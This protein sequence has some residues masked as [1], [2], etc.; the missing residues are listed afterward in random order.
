MKMLSTLHCPL[1]AV[2]L[3]ALLSLP[4]ARGDD[5]TT[6]VIKFSDPAKPGVVK[7]DVGHGDIRIRG[8]EK[9][10]AVTLKT[11]AKMTT[12]APRS[13]GL[14]NLTPPV[15][16]SL[17]E[18]NNVVTIE[19]TSDG[20]Q[21]SGDFEINVPQKTS[22]VIRNSWGGSITCSNL[23]GDV[24][25]KSMNG[26]VK[27]DGIAGGVLVETMNGEIS[28]DMREVL[29]GK[30]LS[31]T[32]MNG[33]IVIRVPEQTKAT[34]SLRSQ[35]AAILTDFDE[36]ALVTETK[37]LP[38]G[39]K[40]AHVN[41]PGST[42]IQVAVRDAIAVGLDV[43]REATEAARQAADAMR[44]ATNSMKDNGDMSPMPKMKSVPPMTGGKI[45][46][47]ALNGGG[48]DIQAATMNG[49]VILRKLEPKK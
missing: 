4:I 10:T 5:T 46:S 44:D 12:P 19:G 25:I 36:K 24:E 9:E 1:F 41:P 43:A 33:K 21:Q 42:D 14:R 23:N 35:N 39:K 2:A 18:Q 6:N 28:A 30:P 7:V 27:L 13:D 17:S 40:V 22:V 20:P 15:S 34:V 48:V 3:S 11:N 47:G 45:V 38:R 29:D 37:S 31:F 32:S 26:R 16:V 49:E 8:S